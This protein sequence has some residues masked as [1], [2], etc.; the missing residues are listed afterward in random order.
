M[1][2]TTSDPDRA[3]HPHGWQTIRHFAYVDRP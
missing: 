2:Q 3:A 1:Y